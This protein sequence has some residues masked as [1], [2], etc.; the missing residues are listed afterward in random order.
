MSVVLLSGPITASGASATCAERVSGWIGRTLRRH[1]GRRER[2]RRWGGD[3]AVQYRTLPYAS[4]V[5]QTP[6]DGEYSGSLGGGGGS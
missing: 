2:L 5:V 4:A 6:T 3:G 1:R